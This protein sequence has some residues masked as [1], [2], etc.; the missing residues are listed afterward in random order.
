MEFT[1]GS[2]SQNPTAAFTGSKMTHDFLAKAIALNFSDEKTMFAELYKTTALNDLAKAL[3]CSPHLLRKK[4]TEHG[5]PL[6]QRGGPNS[7][8][9]VMN[10]QVIKD[11][12]AKGATQV[13]LEQKVSKY[14]LF[15]QRAKF[16]AAK[17]QTAAPTDTTPQP[18]ASAPSD[19][20]E[21]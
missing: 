11:M 4:L 19:P 3:G 13:A 10:E 7:Q 9:C 5:I 16:L 2:D 14:T 6:R 1:F 15:R 21:G 20:L 17:Q 8:K 18:P 12:E